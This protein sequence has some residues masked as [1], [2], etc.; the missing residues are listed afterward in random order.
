[1]NSI[2]ILKQNPN[3]QI[4]YEGT[5]KKK[6]MTVRD[7]DGKPVQAIV[8]GV[9]KKL[10]KKDLKKGNIPMLPKAIGGMTTDVIEVG[11]IYANPPIRTQ[12]REPQQQKWRPIKAGTSCGH[13]DI[14]CGTLG[15]V[16]VGIKTA[17]KKTLSNDNILSRIWNWLMRLFFSD[18]TPNPPTPDPEDPPEIETGDRFI[19]S[20][21][22]VLNNENCGKKGDTVIQPGDYDGGTKLDAVATVHEAVYIDPSG[23][24]HVDCC[25]AKINKGIES[26]LGQY[27]DLSIKSPLLTPKVGLKVNKVGRTTFYTEG[28]ITGINAASRIWYDCGQVLFEKQIVIESVNPYQF[29]DGGDSGSLI[30]DMDGRPVALLF[31]GSDVITLANPIG[32]VMDSLKTK[33]TFDEMHPERYPITIRKVAKHA[34]GWRIKWRPEHARGMHRN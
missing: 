33:F 34:G 29:S 19:L 8:F 21:L 18:D 5:K 15:A 6:E 23:V 32:L 27:G 20:N 31:A 2:D 16:V 4:V 3:V 22:H 11:R 12:T 28:K 24:N 10:S 25:L 30:M 7:K 9:E 13:I 17:T 1:L 14:T 26:K